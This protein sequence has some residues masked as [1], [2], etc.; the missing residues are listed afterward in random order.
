LDP[1]KGCLATDPPLGAARYSMVDEDRKA[2]AAFLS[3]IKTAPLISSAPAHDFR[4]SLVKL[5]CVACHEADEFKPGEDVEKLPVL[6][7]IGAKLKRDWIGQVLNDKRARVRFWLKTRMPEFGSAVS[8]VPDQAVAAAG[9]DDS[10]EP[11]V[12]P[13]TTLIAEGQKL[14]GANDPKKNP[15]GMGC[16]TCHSLREFKP[17]VA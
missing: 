14:V 8:R 7:N 17:A 16:V 10:A 1:S 13:N 5:N 6:T 12:I 9:V 4:R 15:S 3:A 11:K 2:I